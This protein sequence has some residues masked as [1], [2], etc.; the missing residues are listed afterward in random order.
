MKFWFDNPPV[1][2]VISCKSIKMNSFGDILIASSLI[3]WCPISFTEICKS[4]MA[5]R[6]VHGGILIYSR[7]TKHNKTSNWSSS[8][9]SYMSWIPKYTKCSFRLRNNDCKKHDMQ[10]VVHA[11]YKFCWLSQLKGPGQSVILVF[12]YFY[13]CFYLFFIQF[14]I[15]H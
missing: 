3:K 9:T 4:K 8:F 5:L 1:R 15:S 14:S 12:I 10:F 7:T 6:S 13:W 11:W 2:S